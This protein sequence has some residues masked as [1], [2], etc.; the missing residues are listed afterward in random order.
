[1]IRRGLRADMLQL[2]PPLLLPLFWRPRLLF[3]AVLVLIQHDLSRRP[4][5]SS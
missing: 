4:S 3:A 2:V 1:M 5:P